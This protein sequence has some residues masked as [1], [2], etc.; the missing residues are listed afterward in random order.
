MLNFSEARLY[1]QNE[2]IFA[3]KRKKLLENVSCKNPFYVCDAT[4]FKT[5]IVVIFK[6]DFGE[7]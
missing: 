4:Q 5:L 6:I 7:F 3:W 1:S 2:N